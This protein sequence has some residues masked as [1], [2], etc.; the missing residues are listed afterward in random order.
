MDYNYVSHNGQACGVMMST[1]PNIF[2]P[3][4]IDEK[5][6][7]FMAG[8][9]LN[10]HYYRGQNHFFELSY[11]S[12]YRLSDDKKL[13][14]MNEKREFIQLLK[15]HPIIKELEELKIQNSSYC[16]DYEG[17]AQHYGFATNHMDIT[18]DKNIAMFFACTEY[19]NGEY[20]PFETS[21]E[22]VLYT[23]N[24]FYQDAIERLNIIGAHAI[25]RPAEQKAFSIELSENENFNDLEFVKY[26]KFICTKELSLK[27]FDLFDGG[28]KLFPPDLV[29]KKAKQIQNRKILKKRDSYFT[30]KELSSIRMDWIKNRDNFYKMIANPRL[31]YTV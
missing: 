26:K 7:K 21:R 24:F 14:A 31:T 9:E 18:N 15:T 10:F 11:P 2:H 23:I 27:Y 29:D 28:K 22:V 25:P 12:I 30:R 6:F 20:F 1:N 4:N 16:T 17:L 3:V 8:P 5:C 19:I 13:Q